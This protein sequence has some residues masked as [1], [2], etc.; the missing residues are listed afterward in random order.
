MTQLDPHHGHYNSGFYQNSVCNT[1][2]DTL[3]INSHNGFGMIWL[4]E[5]AED[6]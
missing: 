5:E 3:L 4:L 6:V 2:H 1:K